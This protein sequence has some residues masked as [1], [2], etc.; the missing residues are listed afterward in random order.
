MNPGRP[1]IAVLLL[2]LA[3]A[4]HAE[5]VVLDAAP[6]VIPVDVEMALDVPIFGSSSSSAATIPASVH[7]AVTAL[8]VSPEGV[9]ESTDASQPSKEAIGTSLHSMHRPRFKDQRGLS[10]N[11]DVARA[12][13]ESG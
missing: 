5:D 3:G 9:L 8:S 7:A 2:P 13:G 1:L 10:Q 11:G 6:T 12:Q 4:L